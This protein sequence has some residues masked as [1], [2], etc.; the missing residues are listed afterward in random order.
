MGQQPAPN[1]KMSVQPAFVPDCATTARPIDW[2]LSLTLVM[3][4]TEEQISG[5][6]M[7]V[8]VTSQTGTQWSF[9]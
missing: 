1:P 9:F 3:S 7:S 5:R 8:C 6:S 2:L 4:S